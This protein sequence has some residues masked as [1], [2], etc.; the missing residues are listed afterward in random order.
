MKIQKII[1]LIPAIVSCFSL[2]SFPA[3]ALETRCGWLTNPTPANCYLKDTDG[4]WT[5]SVQGGYQASGKVFGRYRIRN[6]SPKNIPHK[7][8]EFRPFIDFST[9]PIVAGAIAGT[10]TTIVTGEGDSDRGQI[11]YTVNII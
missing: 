7:C 1:R 3:D 5:L 8:L 10:N 4:S 11:C 2:N 9:D 6:D